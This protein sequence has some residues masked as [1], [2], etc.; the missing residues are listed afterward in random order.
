LLVEDSEDVR[1]WACA[2]LEENGNT[3]NGAA[4]GREALNWLSTND[5][6]CLIL[7][8]L[9]MPEMNGLELAEALSKHPVWSEIPIVV[10]TA[11]SMADG[12]ELRAREFLRKPFDI[13]RLLR[14][15]QHCTHHA[16]F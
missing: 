1:D 8:D 4:N 2:V 15:T 11:S 7:L 9:Q 12:L 3:V 16:A 10:M 6:P 13:D 14:T 5:A